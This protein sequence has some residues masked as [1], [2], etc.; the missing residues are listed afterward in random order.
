MMV[1]LRQVELSGRRFGQFRGRRSRSTIG[2][3]WMG[4]S[5]QPSEGV[6]P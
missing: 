4:Y 6:L 3:R 5:R 2:I 1:K